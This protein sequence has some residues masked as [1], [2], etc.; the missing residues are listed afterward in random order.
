M[1]VGLLIRIG[2]YAE[3]GLYGWLPL[4]MIAAGLPMMFI[5]AWLGDRLLRNLDEKA[6]ARLLGLVLMVSGA[7]LLLS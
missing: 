1:L 7:G 4:T 3:L 6:F 2:G 5:G